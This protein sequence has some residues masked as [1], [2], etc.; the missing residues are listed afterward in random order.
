MLLVL[1]LA[2]V[3]LYAFSSHAIQVSKECFQILQNVGRDHAYIKHYFGLIFNSL[4]QE[5]RNDTR[6]SSLLKDFYLADRSTINAA[7]P[8]FHASATEY[9]KKM[10][11]K[12]TYLRLFD[13]AFNNT[14]LERGPGSEDVAWRAVEELFNKKLKS[15][16]NKYKKELAEQKTTPPISQSQGQGLVWDFGEYKKH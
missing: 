8:K 2:C 4:A 15:V 1:F 9:L 7:V 13:A 14:I 12:E 6:L 5:K 11:C 16:V 3:P 10:V